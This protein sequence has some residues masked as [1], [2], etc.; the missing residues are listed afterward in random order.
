MLLDGRP[1][2]ESQPITGQL[3]PQHV[4]LEVGRAQTMT[5]VVDF[6][7]LGDVQDHADWAEARLIR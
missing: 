7:A 3:A 2:W 4:Q 5:L 1:A 6:G